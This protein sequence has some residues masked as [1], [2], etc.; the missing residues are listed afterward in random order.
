MKNIVIFA[1]TALF[2]APALLFAEAQE[3][4]ITTYYPAPYGEY[5]NVKT[6]SITLPARSDD[7]FTDWGSG[8]TG[9][10][11]YS[12]KYD[13][14]YRFNGNNW[15]ALEGSGAG[16]VP[17]QITDA[18]NIP[19]SGGA[20]GVT[21]AAAVSACRALGAGW[22]VPTVEELT[23]FLGH[24]NVVDDDASNINDYD[25]WTITPAMG[26]AGTT[27]KSYVV[28]RLDPGYMTAKTY[29]D[30]EWAGAGYRCVK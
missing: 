12:S 9:E 26:A 27:N 1:L 24:S 22:H 4:K 13:G 21:L 6:D 25:I 10:I 11:Y 28:M 2:I 18:F 17:T 19:T 23:L 3:M 29:Y 30:A 14:L 16:G 5:D 7:P 20:S 8:A 15:V